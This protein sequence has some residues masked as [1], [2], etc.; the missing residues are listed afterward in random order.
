M[1]DRASATLDREDPLETEVIQ[2]DWDQ[3]A[4]EVNVVPKENP[5]KK[6]PLETLGNQARRVSQ[7]GEDPEGTLD[8]MGTLDRRAILGS[9]TVMS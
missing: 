2:V 5:E 1:E 4:A 9:L 3:G 8:L 7:E 6:D